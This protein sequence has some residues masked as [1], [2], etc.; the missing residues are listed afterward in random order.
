M[1][2]RVQE[3]CAFWRIFMC[4]ISLSV[5][6]PPT[7]HT[8]ISAVLLLPALSLHCAVTG[9]VHAA[10]I[11]YSVDR[12]HSRKRTFCDRELWPVT[13]NFQT[14]WD[15]VQMIHYTKYPDQMSFSSE[16]IFWTHTHLTD[17]STGPLKWS[18]NILL[19]NILTQSKH[20]SKVS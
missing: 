6:T 7:R 19:A 8:E 11:L 18:V 17:F 12:I 20:I 4:K 14:D 15:S 5:C 3:W 10:F 16:V 13:L 9:S 2:Q 1:T